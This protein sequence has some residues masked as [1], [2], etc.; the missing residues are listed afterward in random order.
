MS[1]QNSP[2]ADTSSDDSSLE[3]DDSELGPVMHV[4]E[5]LPSTT[6]FEYALL[7]I[8]HVL[9]CLYRFLTMLRAPMPINRIQKCASVDV[10]GYESWDIQHVASK[11]T[12]LFTTT[13]WAG[14]H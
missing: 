6:E 12:R 11:F 7:D 4:E 1:D 14:K 9:K 3:E 10:K 2:E 13:S 5:E 8:S